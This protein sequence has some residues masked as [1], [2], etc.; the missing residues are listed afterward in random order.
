MFEKHEAKIKLNAADA[1]DK[2]ERIYIFGACA[3]LF[4]IGASRFALSLIR[5]ILRSALALFMSL[6][7]ALSIAVRNFA[8]PYGVGLH[9]LRSRPHSPRLSSSAV[10]CSAPDLYISAALHVY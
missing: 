1:V 9:S 2:Y 8:V 4:L 6:T 5:K 7:N 3:Y 10:G